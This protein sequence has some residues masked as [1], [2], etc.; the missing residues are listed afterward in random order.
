M[1]PAEPVLTRIKVKDKS[2]V[3]EKESPRN[4]KEPATPIHISTRK[5]GRER[6][7]RRERSS[8]V[9]AKRQ[10]PPAEEKINICNK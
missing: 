8:H 3:Q 2:T 10:V 7:E 1:M 6:R 9:Q 4:T 5:A